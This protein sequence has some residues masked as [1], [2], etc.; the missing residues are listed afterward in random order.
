ME[1]KRYIYSNNGIIESAYR[2][3]NLGKFL[4]IIIRNYSI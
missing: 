2:D 3:D 1:V 4:G